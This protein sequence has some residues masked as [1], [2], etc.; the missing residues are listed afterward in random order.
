M[1]KNS[2][3]HYYDDG[4]IIIV[5]KDVSICAHKRYLSMASKIF[6]DMC[7]CA[8]A[9]NGQLPIIYLDEESAITFE[10]LLSFLYPS[11]YVRITW[12]NIEPFL[13]LADKYEINIVTHASEDFLE[14]HYEDFPLKSLIIADFFKF[15]KV[16]KE[17]SK[18]VLNR[19]LDYRKHEDFK[20][21]SFRTVAALQ[22]RYLDY[23]TAIGNLG[24][25]KPLEGFTHDLLCNRHSHEEDFTHALDGLIKKTKVCPAPAPSTTFKSFLS[26]G[27]S[28]GPR[29]CSK[30]FIEIY[31]MKFKAFFGPMEP[32]ENEKRKADASYY[33][34]IEPMS[35]T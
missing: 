28:M 22:S 20:R 25:F 2:S 9:I 27:F 21:L 34:F 30:S 13:Q 33:I 29:T 17:S 11:Q 8:T 15:N 3:L 7:S 18:L 10:E 19:L 26:P 32:L 31:K 5:I 16:Y 35:R 14:H 6:S 23:I 4:D 12:N 1:S 24:N